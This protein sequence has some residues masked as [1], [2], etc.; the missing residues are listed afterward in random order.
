MVLKRW[1]RSVVA[2]L[3][4]GAAIVVPQSAA[5]AAPAVAIG[6]TYGPY[7]LVLQNS[8]VPPRTPM[9]LDNPASNMSDNTRMEIYSCTANA[10][11]QQW[12]NE[13]A[14]TTSDFWTFNRAS[15]KCLTVKG[16]STATGAAIIQYGC[17]KG[18]NERWTYHEVYR[19]FDSGVIAG[20]DRPEGIVF[21]IQNMNS[22]QCLTTVNDSRANKT[23][24][25][26]VSCA[27]SNAHWI[28]FPA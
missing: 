24:L 19:A 11:N 23:L 27:D 28:Q 20:K 2:L 16:A 8:L 7:I 18:T 13:T 14:V 17:T 9:C 26:Q 15:R 4:I 5:Q 25:E 1:L 3:S 10:L 21:Y 6:E 22:G 12:Y